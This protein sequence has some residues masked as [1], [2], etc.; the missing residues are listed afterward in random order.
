MVHEVKQK[1]PRTLS[2][3][4]SG[5]TT[6]RLGF[7]FLRGRVTPLPRQAPSV[8]PFVSATRVVA[9]WQPDICTAPPTRDIH[10]EILLCNHGYRAASLRFEM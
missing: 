9:K 7:S 3:L 10:R 2:P 8:F 6:L 4:Q 5:P 1:E